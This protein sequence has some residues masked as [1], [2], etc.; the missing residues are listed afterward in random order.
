[1]N[2]QIRYALSCLALSAALVAGCGG[3]PYDQEPIGQLAQKIW[4]PRPYTDPMSGV[5]YP[6]KVAD[7]SGNGFGSDPATFGPIPPLYPMPSPISGCFWQASYFRADGTVAS[8]CACVIAVVPPDW[9]GTY[10][11]APPPGGTTILNVKIAW[12]GGDGLYAPCYGSKST[13]YILDPKTG[14]IVF[15]G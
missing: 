13:G 6:I 1:M 3:T 12:H 8:G 7:G 5:T 15:M 11:V 9:S 14:R 10:T 4:S 2:S